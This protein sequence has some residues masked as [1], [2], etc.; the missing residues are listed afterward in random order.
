VMPWLWILVLLFGRELYLI[1]FRMKPTLL[2]SSVIGLVSC[3]SLF[4]VVHTSSVLLISP[5]PF[6]HMFLVN[7]FYCRSLPYRFWLK[8]PVS[9]LQIEEQKVPIMNDLISY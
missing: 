7:K 2:I 4:C 6:A 1:S 8:K 9:I 3:I 5:S